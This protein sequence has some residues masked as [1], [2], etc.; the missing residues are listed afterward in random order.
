MASVI[1]SQTIHGSQQSFAPSIEISPE[2]PIEG[3]D[4]MV[5]SVIVD[6]DGQ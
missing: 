5:C 4:D 1:P 2:D 3:L 6:T